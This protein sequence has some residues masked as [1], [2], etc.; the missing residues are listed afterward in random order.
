MCKCRGIF[1]VL[2]I[3]LISCQTVPVQRLQEENLQLQQEL[4]HSRNRELE[5]QRQVQTLKEELKQKEEEIGELKKGR[6]T[7][8]EVRAT[9]QKDLVNLRKEVQYLQQLLKDL[10]WAYPLK[11]MEQATKNT[12][13]QQTGGRKGISK[14]TLADGG[15][16]YYDSF[17]D[18]LP[19]VALYLSIEERK[20]AN[21]QL[22]LNIR[23]TYWT[24]KP[25]YQ[26]VSIGL[27]REGQLFPL[28]YT[29]REAL[30]TEQDGR[31]LQLVRLP[32]QGKVLDIFKV[33]VQGAESIRLIFAFPDFSREH[34]LSSK[35]VE[36]LGNV[37]QAYIEM[38]GKL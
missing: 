25:D 12:F 13:S 23:L 20:E 4:S 34:P 29:S 26:L 38:G 3:V 18:T 24:P 30:I 22:F 9:L 31:R 37:Y 2:G 27:S 28:S 8:A 5:L 10:E 17:I 36:A 19:P 6:E 7:E 16:E 33:I 1:F 32:V 14:R 15:V 21:L 11:S 35:E